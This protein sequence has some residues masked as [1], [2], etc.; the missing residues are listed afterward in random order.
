M[1][2]FQTKR[3]DKIEE[4]ELRTHLPFFSLVVHLTMELKKDRPPTAARPDLT[5][6]WRAA[7]QHPPAGEKEKEGRQ[8]DNVYHVDH[9]DENVDVN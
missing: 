5:F 2:S 7:F 1:P 6:H 9:A 8:V 4:T 3:L